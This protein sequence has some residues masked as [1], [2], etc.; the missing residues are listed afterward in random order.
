MPSVVRVLRAK[1]SELCFQILAALTPAPDRIKSCEVTSGKPQSQ[2]INVGVGL[3][4]LYQLLHG[5][6]F[7]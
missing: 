4:L 3:A 1:S 6:E 7:S 5:C 2:S